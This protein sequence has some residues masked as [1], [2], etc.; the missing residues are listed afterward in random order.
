[1]QRLDELMRKN[2]VQEQEI[3][4]LRGKLKEKTD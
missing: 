4:H 2:E 1:M 3:A